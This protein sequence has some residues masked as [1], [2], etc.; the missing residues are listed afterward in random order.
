MERLT[1]AFK[2]LE[3]RLGFIRDTCAVATE[4]QA[5]QLFR[6]H[7]EEFVRCATASV[8]TAEE[9]QARKARIAELEA[10]IAELEASNRALAVDGRVKDQSL[11]AV[12]FAVNGLADRLQGADNRTAQAH[13][14]R[15]HW[16]NRATELAND[17]AEL[18]RQ[19]DEAKQSCLT[20]Q[21]Q[22]DDAMVELAG[23]L[24]DYQRLSQQSD[25]TKTKLTTAQEGLDDYKTRLATTV[26]EVVQ[27]RMEL[28]HSR[29]ELERTKAD[30]ATVQ[31]RLN[32]VT[33]ERD[34]AT[35]ERTALHSRVAALVNDL[36]A[37]ESELIRS[38]ETLIAKDTLL[39]SRSE[40]LT[41]K[42]AEL[43]RSDEA[44]A[45]MR[46]QNHDLEAKVKDLGRQL[47]EWLLSAGSE[48][49]SR[50]AAGGS[51]RKR[52]DELP[53]TTAVWLRMAQ[54]V[55][56]YLAVLRLDPEHNLPSPALLLGHM[57]QVLVNVH[58]KVE[59][60]GLDNLTSLRTSAPLDVWFCFDEAMAR[61]WA[62]S[63]P[64]VGPCPSH[65]ECFQIKR[66]ANGV[67]FRVD[68]QLI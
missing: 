6:E 30:L 35:S 44:L 27:T 56:D 34:E 51:K 39:T 21:E 58:L 53:V 19:L 8:P 2:V 52:N 64:A 32:D 61:G 17:K 23:A 40:A 65:S 42:K 20:H 26:D 29:E 31:Q 57:L 36:A 15:D 49:R 48:G 66:T 28:A 9:Q 18:Q 16:R 45:T 60:Q 11:E 10:R 3:T 38:D 43:T 68:S 50:L 12:N 63:V 7:A 41:A 14:Q 13:S 46:K 47:E 4:S 25:E 22:A 24:D 37:K 33:K 59:P 54:T 5:M 67:A 62:A 55:Y 1:D